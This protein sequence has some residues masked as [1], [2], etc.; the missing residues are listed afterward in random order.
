MS[1]LGHNVIKNIMGHHPV[2]YIPKFVEIGP[3][4]PKDNIFRAFQNIWAWKPSGHVTNII[5]SSYL[6]VYVQNFVKE[7]Q[8]VSSISSEI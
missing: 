1:S 6:K 2:C 5:I 3:L 4:V 8:V 7:G